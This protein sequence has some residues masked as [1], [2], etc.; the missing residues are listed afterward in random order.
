[1]SVVLPASMCPHTEMLRIAESEMS[2]HLETDV[3]KPIAGK[4]DPELAV[5]RAEPVRPCCRVAE[6][7]PGPCRYKR[8]GE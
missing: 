8:L 1:M 7:L 4:N 6:M 3:A 2:W 5:L